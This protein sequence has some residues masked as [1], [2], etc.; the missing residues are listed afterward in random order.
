MRTRQNPRSDLVEIC[1]ALEAAGW[2][3][4][5][6][7]PPAR[8]TARPKLLVEA[9]K[10]NVAGRLVRKRLQVPR[11]ERPDDIVEAF[12]ERFGPPRAED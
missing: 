5:A 3:E 4:P 10:F 1:E 11:Y 6:C 7:E 8:A 12:A 2:H 9:S